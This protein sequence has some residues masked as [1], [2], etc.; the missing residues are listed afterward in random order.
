MYNG[1]NRIAHRGN[2]VRAPE[3]TWT[4]FQEAI[5]CGCEGIELDLRKSRDGKVVV[6]HDADCRRLS[7][8]GHRH[9][10]DM[11]L[12]EWDWEELKQISLPFANHLMIDF[13]DCP[14]DERQML[15]LTEQIQ[16]GM[17]K[18]FPYE[19]AFR[20]DGRRERL[21]L[22]E[23][24]FNRLAVGSWTGLLEL[25]LKDEGLMNFLGPLLEK[26]P[27]LGEIYLMSGVETI[28]SEIQD[29]YRIHPKPDQLGLS[30][31]YRI[32][33]T[34][35][36]KRIEGMDLQVVGLNAWKFDSN[37]VEYLNQLGIKTFSNLGD[38]PKWW[39][40]LQTLGVGGFKTNYLEEYS[41][42]WMENNE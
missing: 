10:S 22:L 9:Y 33:D 7:C 3:N 20:E 6:M 17:E 35:C 34:Q 19:I 16:L 21:M 37:D 4:A 28:I 26:T 8:E 25:E 5:F 13:K 41:K 12:R 32:L 38:T 42:W 40:M 36:K 30:A 24:L 29:Y 39:A 15:D 27:F 18:R 11:K 1:P 14:E 23:D 2:V 31:N